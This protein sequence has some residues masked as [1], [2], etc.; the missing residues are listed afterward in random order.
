MDESNEQNLSSILTAIASVGPDANKDTLVSTIDSS[1]DTIIGALGTHEAG[2]ALDPEIAKSTTVTLQFLEQCSQMGDEDFKAHIK[3][4]ALE[5]QQ[6]FQGAMS[7]DAAAAAAAAA[8]AEAEATHD[9]FESAFTDYFCD[10]L[11]ARLAL[12]HVDDSQEPFPL[13]PKFTDVFIAAVRKF[14]VPDMLN[15]RRIRNMADSISADQL[16]KHTFFDEFDKPDTENIVLLIWEDRVKEFRSAL[17]ESDVNGI[18]KPKKKKEEKK[19][20]GLLGKFK[21]QETKQ[22]V[23]SPAEKQ[24]LEKAEGF[25][26]AISKADGYDSPQFGDFDIFRVLMIYKPIIV[27]EAKNAL[28]QFLEQEVKV[29]ETREGATRDWL[30]KAVDRLPAHCGE[31]VVL[32]SYMTFSDIFSPKIVRSFLTGQGTTDAERKRAVP[33]FMRWVGMPEIVEE[34][35]EELVPEEDA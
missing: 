28:R 15:H 3:N 29:G 20:G 8:P 18:P 21:K 32:W 16:H 26:K 35:D 13:N 4:R 25:W 31:L 10:F 19:K 14:I 7:G 5:L 9:S 22:T 33:L 34:E 6:V 1:V 24:I 2:S 11:R 23:Q 12:F 30:Y 17:A 27:K